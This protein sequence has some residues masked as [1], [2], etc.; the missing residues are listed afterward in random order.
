MHDPSSV[1]E[2]SVGCSRSFVPF[3]DII[4]RASYDDETTEGGRSSEHEGTDAEL[5]S[6]G[7]W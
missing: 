3:I 7:L 4:G 5:D 6:R 1:T 2:Y